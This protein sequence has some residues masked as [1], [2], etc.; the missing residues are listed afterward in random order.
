[1]GADKCSVRD[2]GSKIIGVDLCKAGR[3]ISAAADANEI[4]GGEI[5]AHIRKCMKATPPP[6]PREAEIATLRARVADLKAAAEKAVI[7]SE[8][9]QLRGIDMSEPMAVTLR[10]ALRSPTPAPDGDPA[11]E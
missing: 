1:M 10:A 11:D 8:M 2:L 4:D 5:I 7:M 3:L 9:G 6:D